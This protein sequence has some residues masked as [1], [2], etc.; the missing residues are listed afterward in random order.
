IAGLTVN[1]ERIEQALTRNPIL[2][3]AL[4]P[5]V[6]YERAAQIAKRAYSESKPILEVAA[7]MTNI[8]KKQLE[9]LLNPAELTKGGIKSGSSGG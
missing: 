8:D 1:A 3:T 6:G 5:I 9:Q 7:S 4:N 2:V